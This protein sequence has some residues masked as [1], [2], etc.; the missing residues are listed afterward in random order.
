MPLMIEAIPSAD[1]IVLIITKVEDPEESGYPV[2]LSLLLL[3][4]IQQMLRSRLSLKNS[5]V[6][7][8]SLYTR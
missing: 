2:L 5:K 6:Q 8:S 4:L 3:R 1:S 7:N